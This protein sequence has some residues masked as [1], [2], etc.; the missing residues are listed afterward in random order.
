[1]GERPGDDLI[2]MCY[3]SADFREGMEAFLAKRA[4]HWTGR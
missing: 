2:R 4:P 3:T 1:M